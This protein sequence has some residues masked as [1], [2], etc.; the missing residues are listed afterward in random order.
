MI[1]NDL[2]TP[3]IDPTTPLTLYQAPGSVR[4]WPHQEAQS[5]GTQPVYQAK[6]EACCGREI[7]ASAERPQRCMR[8][9]WTG[10]EELPEGEVLRGISRYKEALQLSQQE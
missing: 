8:F 5:P 7:G 4:R 6:G 3:F 9:P 1:R 10:Q 2:I